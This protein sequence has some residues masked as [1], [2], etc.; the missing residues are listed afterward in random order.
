MT[1]YLLT[2]ALAC[3]TVVPS[4]AVPGLSDADVKALT[5]KVNAAMQGYNKKNSKTFYKDW[6][7]QVAAIQTDQ[8]FQSLYINIYQNQYG[9]YQSAT[10]DPAKST[11]SDQNGLLAYNAKFSK[12]PAK[13]M[14][15][16]FKEGDWKIQQ[17]QLAP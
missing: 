3:L 13:L 16:F 15:N 1:K 8:A 11:F 5:A 10:L 4:W 2:A 6:A 14:V 7:K 17:I 9:T 12:K